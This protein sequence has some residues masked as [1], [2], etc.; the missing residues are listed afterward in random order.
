MLQR[1]R[2]RQLVFILCLACLTGLSF[3]AGAAEGVMITA[4]SVSDVKVRLDGIPSELPGVWSSLTT[5]ISG[6]RTSS[7][8]Q[9][10]LA[11]DDDN[12]YLAMKMDDSKIVRSASAGNNEDH[13]TLY[14]AFPVGK[15]QFHTHVVELFPGDPGKLPGIV[16]MGG[17]APAG[18]QLVEAPE[19]GGLTFEA[20]IPWKSFPEAARTR[21]GMRAGVQWTDATAPGHVASVTSTTRGKEG[22]ALPQLLTEPEQSLFDGFIRAQ[23]LSTEPARVLLADVAGDSLYE[24]VALYDHFLTVVGTHFRG[25][26]EFVVADL[27]VQ[28]PGK[29]KRLQPADFDGDGHDEIVTVVRIGSEDHY[30]DVVE[31][32]HIDADNSMKPIFL[33]EVG[34][35]AGS[36]AIDNEVRIGR[37]GG[38]STLTIAQGSAE[39][40]EKEGYSEPKPADME[41]ALLPWDP[42][43]SQ[44]YAWQGGHLVKAGET[45]HTPSAH[46]TAKGEKRPAVRHR[47][48]SEPSNTVAVPP[49]P[50]PPTTDEMLD[51]VYAMYRKDR[52]VKKAKP[53]FDFVTDVA[54]DTTNERV[55]VHDKDIVCF[56]K[57]F[58]E[59]TTYVYTAVGVASPDDII[60]VTARDLTGD[61]KAEVIVL[62]QL[63]AKAGKELDDASVDRAV[64]FIF[65]ITETGVRRV[66][67]AETARSVSDKTILSGIR[68][69]PRETGMLIELTAGRSLGF[70]PKSYPFPDETQAAGG[71]E[72]VVL[73]WSK[74]RNR[75]YRFDGDRF[76]SD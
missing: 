11:Y 73:P 61:G 71:V 36:G 75:S 70:T 6:K 31:V 23:H 56:G 45:S 35:T 40:V 57:G 42:I 46:G 16:R 26:K 55:L 7:N 59:G 50:R 44:T 1:M 33:H 21:V 41:S 49:A 19:S 3:G 14:L 65:Q 39:G 54:G 63:R 37:S 9:C 18:A 68:F 29:V 72:P 38:R 5:V 2:Q 67:A 69:L 12:L 28:D 8:A 22:K 34:L 74:Q 58:R 48:P 15:G 76:A 10:A 24:R 25:G 17:H 53:R 51:Q 64:L 32:L 4:D 47:E 13:A 43:G 62:G 30:R 66:F 27:E 20:K 60:D 52:H